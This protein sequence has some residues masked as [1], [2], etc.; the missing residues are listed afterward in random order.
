MLLRTDGITKRFGD[1]VA[2]S[3]VGLEVRR[4]EV[5]GIIGPNGAGK[6]TLV[7]MLSGA[8][9]ADGGSRAVRRRRRHASA[10]VQARPHGHRP[11]PPDPA[12]VPP[13]DGARESPRGAVLRRALQVRPGRARGLRGHPPGAGSLVGG[14]R[15]GRRPHPAAA[16]A[17]R[18]GARARARAAHPA[19]GRDRRRPRRV[20]DRRAHRGHQGSAASGRGHRHHRAHHGRDPE[21]LRQSGRA[22]LRT[23]HRRR[24]RQRRDDHPGGGRL[25]S[26]HRLR[27]ACSVHAL[28]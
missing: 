4:G 15:Q 22:R 24:R 23:T 14:S 6:S 11:H 1:V 25:L 5:L 8:L 28:T 20:G 3:E 9:H 27:G 7:G 2:V 10:G 17:A 13:D 19:H 26:G 18:A 16:Q 12:A 21:M